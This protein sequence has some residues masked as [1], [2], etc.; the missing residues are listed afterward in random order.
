L[1]LAGGIGKVREAVLAHAGGEREQPLGTSLLLRWAGPL[2]WPASAGV[3]YAQAFWADLNA[4]DAM[5]DGV[6][7][8]VRWFPLTCGSGKLVTP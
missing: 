2:I 7:W 5:I 4:G 1:A 3:K 8:S 6:I